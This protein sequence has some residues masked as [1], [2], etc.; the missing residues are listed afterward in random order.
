MI[1][2]AWLIAASVIP[3][4]CLASQLLAVDGL[5]GV[6]YRGLER[7]GIE[8]FLNIP[9]GQDTG[10]PSRFSP[11]RAQVLPR[12]TIVDATEYGPACPQA[13]GPWVIPLSLTNVT[14]MSENCL[15][16]SVARPK[17]ACKGHGLPVMVFIHGGSFWARQNQEA[18]ISPDGMVL[19]SVKNGLPV[20][21]VAMNYRLGSRSPLVQ[22]PCA[23]TANSAALQSLALR[24]LMFSS[25][26]RL[27]TPA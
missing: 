25:P 16:L 4:A 19:E 27:R 26:R 22:I 3:T 21:H 14:E 1:P 18:T 9:Y 12:G 23:F 8:V 10:G 20:I 6:T 15:N 17:G 7:N 13:L 24:S 11:P 5:K 2:S